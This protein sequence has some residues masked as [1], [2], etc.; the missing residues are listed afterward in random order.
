[1]IQSL[2][3]AFLI[4]TRLVRSMAS[5]ASIHI[6]CTWISGI[7]DVAF[8]AFVRKQAPEIRYLKAT[9]SEE[10]RREISRMV[11]STIQQLESGNSSSHSD[12]RFPQNGCV[13]CSHPVT[14]M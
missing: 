14:F 3:E 9:I 12:I 13:S 6:C 8:V 7:P 1:M 4:L 10:Q 5:P 2:G 11:D